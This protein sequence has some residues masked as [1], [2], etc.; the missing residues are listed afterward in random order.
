MCACN[1]S[2][3][4]SMFSPTELTTFEHQMGSPMKSISFSKLTS[5]VRKHTLDYYIVIIIQIL[6]VVD[7]SRAST[8]NVVPLMVHTQH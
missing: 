7:A 5:K 3:L 6:S 4:G 2:I 8:T 1:P